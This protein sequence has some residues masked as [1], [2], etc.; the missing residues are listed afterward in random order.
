[1]IQKIA[2]RTAIELSSDF[3]IPQIP[4][5]ARYVVSNLK[6]KKSGSD[7]N[8]DIDE[9]I[10]RTWYV[11][12]PIFDIT[13]KALYLFTPQ[14][15]D[16][17]NTGDNINLTE[18]DFTQINTGGGFE[19]SSPTTPS[20]G[21]DPQYTK[22]LIYVAEAAGTDSQGTAY[23]K[24]DLLACIASGTSSNATFTKINIGVQPTLP[25]N[26]A[27]WSSPV[28]AVFAI[29]SEVYTTTDTNIQLDSNDN[30]FKTTS[31]DI[32][33]TEFAYNNNQDDWVTV[34][35]ADI[36]NH[37]AIP[38]PDDNDGVSSI[39]VTYVDLTEHFVAL[40]DSDGN[41]FQSNKTIKDFL[42]G[43][44]SS[45]QPSPGVV[46]PNASV[47][48]LVI[49]ESV[50]NGNEE[51]DVWTIQA[52]SAEKTFTLHTGK[53]IENRIFV[54][55]ASAPDK[56]I[57]LVNLTYKAIEQADYYSGTYTFNDSTYVIQIRV[58]SEN[59][60][61]IIV[62]NGLTL[63]GEQTSFA[64]VADGTTVY[65]TTNTGVL[66]S[67]DVVSGG[68]IYRMKFSMN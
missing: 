4:V 13:E 19:V 21:G 56:S 31:D 30:T 39:W 50:V 35:E 9:A 16:W 24:G 63:D 14:S 66:K 2:A 49:T 5:D 11:G 65:N 68:N 61:G 51:S 58:I 43:S 12:M 59:Q 25:E 47:E 57:A 62:L 3:L 8:L 17:S 60:V 10:R 7:T 20:G 34:K 6:A 44:G 23:A 22:G 64:F 32:Y 45:D 1:M 26:V 27:K 55:H 54:K 37:H 33:I 67:M 18:A 36:E 52:G 29:D 48:T 28:K 42:E 46:D 41:L 38:M 15:D 40:M 53:S